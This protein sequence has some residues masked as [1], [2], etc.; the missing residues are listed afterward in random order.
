MRTKKK[1]KIKKIT[2]KNNFL[3]KTNT[4]IKNYWKQKYNL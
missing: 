3:A 2:K 1:N 4:L